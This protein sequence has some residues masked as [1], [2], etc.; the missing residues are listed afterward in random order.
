LAEVTLARGALLLD[1]GAISAIAEGNLQARAALVR[2]RREGRQI[3]IPAVVLAELSTGRP[4][5]ARTDRVIKD[6]DLEIPL[7]AARA[8]EAGTLRARAIANR[9]G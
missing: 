5:D 7:N 3:A 4:I 9:Q 2:A 8:R 6:V 1:S